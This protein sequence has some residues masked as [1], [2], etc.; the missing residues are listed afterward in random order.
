MQLFSI[1]YTQL[2]EKQKT[3]KITKVK[4]VSK[5]KE[6]FLKNFPEMDLSYL[7]V[8]LSNF[9]AKRIKSK[10]G[11]NYLCYRYQR[12]YQSIIKKSVS[13]SLYDSL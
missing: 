12:Y 5:G 13:A 1:T 11:K 4:I 3:K 2:T 7:T 9:K 10:W 6:I 8:L